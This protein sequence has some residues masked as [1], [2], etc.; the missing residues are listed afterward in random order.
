VEGRFTKNWFAEDCQR[1]RI[2]LSKMKEKRGVGI[3]LYRVISRDLSRFLWIFEVLERRFPNQG[4][5][6]KKPAQGMAIAHI[7]QATDAMSALRSGNGK[8]F[9]L[10]I[11]PDRTNNENSRDTCG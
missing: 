3:E 7:F 1:N 4:P 9:R 6:L 2:P 10:P 5:T 8:N 11:R